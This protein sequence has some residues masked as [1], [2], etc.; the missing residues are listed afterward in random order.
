MKKKHNR[1]F[2]S[3]SRASPDWIDS[4]EFEIIAIGGYQP[5]RLSR[6]LAIICK[7]LFE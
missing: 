7:H 2:L 3:I 6:K 1:S 5:M 4:E